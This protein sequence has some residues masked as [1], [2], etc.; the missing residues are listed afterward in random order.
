MYN[1]LLIEAEYRKVLPVI[2]SYGKKGHNIYTIS[3]NKFS[4]GGSSKFVKR[5]Y[6]IRDLNMEF[7]KK[8]IEKNRIDIII[9]CDDYSVKYFS[10]YKE[11]FKIP[12]VVPTLE[13]FKIFRDKLKT[14]QLAESLSVRVPRTYYFEDK[15][16]L[17][18]KM[19]RL[20]KW[21]V[22]V[23]PRK[24]SGSRGLFIAKDLN[25]IINGVS[26]SYIN[27]YGY[28]IIQEYIPPGGKAIGASFLYYKGIEVMHFCHR[29]IR[30]YPPAGG[31][32]TLAVSVYEED[33]VNIGKKLL[34]KV[35]WNGLA[36]VEFRENPHTK[37][38]ILM[39]VNP[40]MWGTIGL[41]LFA[42]ADFADAILRVFLEKEEPRKINKFYKQNYYFRW[43]FPGDFLSIMKDKSINFWNK[44]K[45]LL[46][47][48]K[49][50]IRQI[51][52]IRDPKPIL[53]T[54]FFSLFIVYKN[55]KRK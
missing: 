27:K 25:D 4:I 48:N 5:N 43:F 15:A 7:L 44:L 33:A 46:R 39:E 10:T 32:S 31:P 29:R 36:M 22:V 42:G 41:A 28:P 13:Q 49:P 34:E 53:A 51:L 1:L 26:D 19:N 6:Y 37:E 18:N 8:I 3:L 14:M 20:E 24:S 55:I 9:P 16:H 45:F 12:V 23:K 38:L 2:R 21:P 40:R 30:E 52:S 11:E 17:I 50:V 47:R 35:N 54:L